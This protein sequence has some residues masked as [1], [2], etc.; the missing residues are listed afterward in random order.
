L[1]SE[2]VDVIDHHRAELRMLTREFDN[3]PRSKN[4][5][6]WQMTRW[7]IEQFES[8]I[9]DGIAAGEIAPCDSHIVAVA[10]HTLAHSWSDRA[11]QLEAYDVEAFLAAQLENVLRLVP[12][13]TPA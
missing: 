3:L 6:I 1:F 11:R 12:F 2:Y 5:E 9:T 7:A 13:K 4:H 8:C 10:I